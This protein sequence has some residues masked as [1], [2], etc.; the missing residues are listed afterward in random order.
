MMKRMMM[1]LLIIL[2]CTSIWAGDIYDTSVQSVYKDGYTMIQESENGGYKIGHMQFDY[3]TTEYSTTRNL[4]S[5]N[6]YIIFA[7][8][9]KGV[10]DLDIKVYESVD[11][12]WELVKKDTKIDNSAGVSFRCTRTNKYKIKI[13]AYEFRPGY[14]RAYYGLIVCW[15]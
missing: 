9:D 6:E 7:F 10:K 13:D 8:A 4:Y 2:S 15:K 12:Y 14:D 3:I 11:G 1:I 5:G